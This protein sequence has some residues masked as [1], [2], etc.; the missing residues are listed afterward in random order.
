MQLIDLVLF[1]WFL[2]SCGLWDLRV[3]GFDG[4]LRGFGVVLLVVCMPG[5][6]ISCGFRFLVGLV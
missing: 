2:D 3:C 5:G 4:V 6:V 1:V